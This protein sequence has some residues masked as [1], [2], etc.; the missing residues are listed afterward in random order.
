[1]G[2]DYDLKLGTGEL[3]DF[4]FFF[5]G[6]YTLCKFMVVVWGLGVQRGSITQTSLDSGSSCLNLSSVELTGL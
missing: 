1:M 4:F 5:F 6:C 3:G 2:E